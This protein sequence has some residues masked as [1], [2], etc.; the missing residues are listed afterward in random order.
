MDRH[1]PRIEND[2]RFRTRITE[3]YLKDKRLYYE[4]ADGVEKRDIT[5][6]VAQ[7]SFLGHDFRNVYNALLKLEFPFKVTLE[8]H[9]ENV[10]QLITTRNVDKAKLIKLI[11]SAVMRQVLEWIRE[12]GLALTLNKTVPIF[13]TSTIII[14]TIT[15]TLRSEIVETRSKFKYLGQPS[16]E[17]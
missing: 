8:I 11:L 1:T 9:A 15:L 17:G 3:D 5:A 12:H 7:G 14:T 16:I 10:A 6:G 2:I 4:T 13:R